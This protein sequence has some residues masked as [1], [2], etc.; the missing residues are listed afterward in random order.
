M[1]DWCR[2][3]S[4]RRLYDWADSAGVTRYLLQGHTEP[5]ANAD[6]MAQSLHTR[7]E[8]VRMWNT[9]KLSPKIGLLLLI[10]PVSALSLWALHTHFDGT[11]NRF[12]LCHVLILI[13]FRITFPVFSRHLHIILF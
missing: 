12:I 8:I 7:R 11:S 9:E 13:A 1:E 10:L 2:G 3:C 4:R 5:V 6:I